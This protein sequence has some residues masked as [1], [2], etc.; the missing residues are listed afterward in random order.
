MDYAAP[1]YDDDPRRLS[2][3]LILQGRVIGLDMEWTPD[4][5]KGACSPVAVIQ[6]ASDSLAVLIQT[7]ILA[8]R[9]APL[10]SSLLKFFKCASEPI[11][12]MV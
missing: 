10:P 6:L 3:P 8:K 7:S 1:A 2:I 9:M 5:K 12:L 11:S 4:L